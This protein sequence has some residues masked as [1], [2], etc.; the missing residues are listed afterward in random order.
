[1][2][3]SYYWLISITTE[4]VSVGLVK[5]GTPDTLVA[6]GPETEWLPDNPD[7]FL[8][9]VDVS[10][11]AAA[12]K[13]ALEPDQEPESSA[14]VLPPKWIGNDGKI[15]PEFLKLLESLCR[16]LKLKPLGFISNDEA[17]IESLGK[18][19]S[20]PPSFILVYLGLKEFS[21]SLV[22]LGEVKK[23]FHQELG[24]DFTPQDLESALVSIRLDSALP[25][26]ILVFGHLS[27]SIV[28]D[29]KNYSWIGKQNLETFLHLPDV[30]AYQPEDLFSLYC[31]SVSTQ[32]ENN[33]TPQISKTEEKIDEIV[34]TE[35]EKENIS[36]DIPTDTLTEGIQEEVSAADLGF[37]EITDSDSIVLNPSVEENFVEEKLEPEI[38][39]PSKAKAQI[40]L[41]KFS[42]PKFSLPRFHFNPFLLLPLALSPFL[43]LLPYFF[44]KAE[45]TVN[46]SPIEIN[47]SFSVALD[48]TATSVSDSTIPVI[49]K[50]LDLSFS[51]S[52]VTTGQKETGEK[53]KGEITV[54]N[55][56]DKIQSIPKATILSDP[57]GK[58]YELLTSVQVPASAYNLATG[59]ITMG[60]IKANAIASDIGPEFNLNKDVLLS[61]K[62]NANLLAKVNDSITGG[63][64]RQIKVV[65]G[66][67]K[68][69]LSKNV[70]DSLNSRISSRVEAESSLAG[71]LPETKYIDK[72]V[73]DFNRE[74]GEEA[75]TLTVNASLSIS[76]FQINPSQKEAIL[77]TLFAN[78]AEFLN[79]VST[80]SDFSFSYD[81]TNTSS[82]KSQGKL[83]VVGK[84][85]P[86]L[87]VDSLR[88]KLR[89]QS[90]VNAYKIL[91]SQPKV[92]NREITITPKIFSFLKRLPPSE[93]KITIIQKF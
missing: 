10:L 93:S 48:S 11:S 28:D 63:T 83:T 51:D 34:P 24:T 37:S 20:F 52:I 59:T 33:P 60:Q 29:L 45:V 6:L 39:L 25:P 30:Q 35:A 18:E 41:P 86:R 15:F 78:N 81:S 89:S 87:D 58:K 4:A 31:Q 27:P 72:K 62:D 3:A 55:K 61:F 66:D 22:Y 85:L 17:F 50:N 14:F 64:R 8:H 44:S 88:Q 68:T 47:Q 5:R 46:F 23:R 71:L 38:E 69:K 1:M 32:I 12:E 67:D 21:V 91:D 19:D 65:S 75:D 57:S 13:A 26:Q 73:L 76:V 7:S 49:K 53:S 40:H 92:Y 70:T 90:F 16:S 82:D 80:P 77:K 56:D 84:V 74:V 79:A 9:S 2:E 54:F 42:L 43:L 36:A